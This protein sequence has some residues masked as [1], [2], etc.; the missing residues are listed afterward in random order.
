[1]VQVVARQDS[2]AALVSVN[3][4][5]LDALLPYAAL[6]RGFVTDLVVISCL[7]GAFSIHFSTYTPI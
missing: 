7:F 3:A 4:A 5:S 6:F 1:M 2:T